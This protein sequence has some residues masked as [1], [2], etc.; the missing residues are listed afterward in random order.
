MMA[1]G[2]TDKVKGKAKEA[3]LAATLIVLM[4]GPLQA[5]GEEHVANPSAEQVPADNTGRNV[6]DRDE[7]AKTADQQSN[8]EGDLDITR[9]IR[10]MIVQDK[11]LSTS[12]HNV[13]IVTVDGVV[14]LRG[15]VVS[16]EEKSSIAKK[17]TKVAGVRKVENQ[18][19]VAKP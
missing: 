4:C 10:Q 1:S 8:S 12:A 7:N 18:L 17:A 9:N 14:T 2:T 15:P 6:R 11:S 5:A 16:Q 19:E 3:C 13:K